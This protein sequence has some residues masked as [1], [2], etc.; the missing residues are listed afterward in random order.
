MTVECLLGCWLLYRGL[1][2][3]LWV[4]GGRLLTSVLF[5]VILGRGDDDSYNLLDL[6]TAEVVSVSKIQLAARVIAAGVKY[7]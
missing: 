2:D 4:W 7:L 5:F 3:S 1:L 6:E